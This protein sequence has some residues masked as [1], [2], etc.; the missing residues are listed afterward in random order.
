MSL[1]TN[2]RMWPRDCFVKNVAVFCPS[3][4]SLPESKV[5]RIVL[6]ELTKEVSK[7]KKKLAETLFSGYVL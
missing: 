4:K 5:K 6:I 7:K 2:V 3:L 1:E